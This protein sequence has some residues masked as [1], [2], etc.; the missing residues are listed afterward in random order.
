MPHKIYLLSFMRKTVG[1]PMP[2]SALR[3]RAPPLIR[4]LE[5]CGTGSNTVTG[6]NVFCFELLFCSKASGAGCAKASVSS[7]FASVAAEQE[8]TR[9]RIRHGL[10]NF[11]ITVFSLSR[12]DYFPIIANNSGKVNQKTS[13]YGKFFSKMKDRPPPQ[14]TG[15]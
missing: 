1:P 2:M 8:K 14:T 11:F 10:E 7:A 4:S 3:T 15:Y 5:D 12:S 13:E 6:L 9:A